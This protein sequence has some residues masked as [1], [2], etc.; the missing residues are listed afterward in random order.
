[1]YVDLSTA[2]DSFQLSQHTRGRTVWQQQM[3]AN[4]HQLLS[5]Q[6][7]VHFSGFSASGQFEAAELICN[8]ITKLQRRQP[9]QTHL[10]L[11]QM[12]G[13]VHP[14]SGPATNYP[15]PVCTRNVISRGLSYKCTRCSGW[16]HVKCSEILNVAQYRRKSDWTFDT[17]SVHRPSNRHHQFYPLLRL[18]NRSVTIARSMSYSSMLMESGTSW[19]N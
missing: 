13:D 8:M 7:A 9:D 6:S 19:Q 1:M 2:Y 4:Q 11:L 16:V 18:P 3:P 12:S 15:C 14:N 10:K 17:C 5:W